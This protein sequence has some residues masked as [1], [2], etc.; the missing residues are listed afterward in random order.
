MPI[1]ENSNIHH[2]KT[3]DKEIILI[4]TAHVSRDSAEL[5]EKV[6]GE[7]L[8]D[9]VC[10]ELCQSRYDAITQKTD[11][12]DMDILKIIRD[13]RT[14]LLLSQ[15]IMASFQKKL[16]ERFNINPGEEM[17]RAIKK[18]EETGARIVLADRDIRTTMKRTWRNMRFFRKLRFIYELISSIFV[19]EDIS[20]EDIEKLKERDTLEL[21]LQTF[22]KELPEIKATLIDERDRFLAYSI[23]GAPGSKIVAVVGA[24]HV[25]GILENIDKDIDI[26]AING[27]PPKGKAGQF[28]GW[29]IS[30]VV[31]GIIITGFFHSGNQ[32]GMN[33]I[34]WWVV[35]NG[36][37]AGLGAAVMLAHPV[38]II[39]SAVAAPL[40]SINPMI[41]AGWVA[42]LTE[43]FLRKPRV[44]DFMD[45]KTDISSVKGFWHN[46]I[47]RIL[48]LIVFVNIGSS[49]GTFAAIPLMMR[50]LN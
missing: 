36:V 9:T 39:A 19:G 22:A 37:C 43:A 8:P 12:E 30:A 2:I 47:T 27:V 28:V 3:A 35:V 31:I 23:A 20:E 45:I 14:A 24:G 1:E 10:V 21:A 44:K 7:E 4:G 32:A 26:D 48:L 5:V 50:F 33:M 38:T 34:K 13:K 11:W 49:I 6:I 17:I 25:P 42:G 29:G 16:A 18:A 15:L 40:T 46:K 41:A